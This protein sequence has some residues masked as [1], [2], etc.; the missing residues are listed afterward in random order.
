MMSFYWT[1]NTLD[2][3]YKTNFLISKNDTFPTLYLRSPEQWPLDALVDFKQRKWDEFFN[4]ALTSLYAE[5]TQAYTSCRGYRWP[6]YTYIIVNTLW[7]WFYRIMRSKLLNSQH[8]INAR[9]LIM[10]QLL[11]QCWVKWCCPL[12]PNE[13][14]QRSGITALR[15][16]FGAR[17]RRVAS[18]MSRTLYCQRKRPKIGSCVVSRVVLVA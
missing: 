1:E 8:A 13:V 17:W 5:H 15:I 12:V 2:P 6:I 7:T 9:V 14:T 18:F 3:Y 10:I 4:F 11:W 16:D